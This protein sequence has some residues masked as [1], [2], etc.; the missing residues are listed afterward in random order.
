MPIDPTAFIH[1]LAF[2]CGDVTLGAHASV[3]PFAVI[4][5]DSDRIVVGADTNVQDGAVL[6]TDPGLVC[7]LGAR[8]VVGHRAVVHGATVED[9][10]LVGMG[11]IVLNRAVI[12]A[13]SIVAAGAVVTEGTTIPPNSL[14][15]GAPGR[16]V[17]STTDAHRAGI[18]RGVASYLALQRRH[19]AGEL[20]RHVG[21]TA[22]GA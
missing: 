12:G 17:R 4:R 11:A 9:D 18:R 10:V 15:V 7:S 1:P 3:W 14:V 20:P 22:T 16:V 19:A 8:V 21:E 13:G 6:H 5:A 2:V